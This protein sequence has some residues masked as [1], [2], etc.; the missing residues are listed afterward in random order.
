M[1]AFETGFGMLRCHQPNIINA[2]HASY[3]PR[4]RDLVGL[5]WLDV[6]VLAVR[7]SAS[8]TMDMLCDGH[9]LDTLALRSVG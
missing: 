1:H 2:L 3:E 4:A 8:N 7:R 9:L 5:V 6:L